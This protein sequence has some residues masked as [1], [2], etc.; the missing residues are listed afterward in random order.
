MLTEAAPKSLTASLPV[1]EE[2]IDASFQVPLGQHWLSGLVTG[3]PRLWT[4]LGNLETRSLAESLDKIA[5]EKPIYIAGIARSGS[6]ILLEALAKHADVAT[7]Q[8][9]DFPCLFTPYWWQR[10]QNS[11]SAETAVERA[12]GDGILVTPQSPEAM[13]EVLWQA[14][15]SDAHN[16][17]Q[18]QVLNKDA[19]H[20]RFEKFYRE[21]LQKLLFARGK[22]RYVSKGNYNFSRLGYLQKLFPEIRCIVPIRSPETHV[23][24]LIKQQI[25]FTRGERKYPRALKHM[26]RVGHYEFGLDRRPI[27]TGNT[28]QIS[29]IET[30][31][32]QGDEVRGWARYWAHLYG[33]MADRLESDEKL[34]RATLVIRYEDL[35]S[36]PSSVLE[37]LRVHTDLE[38]DE[39]FADFAHEIHAPTYY[40]PEFS[41]EEEETIREETAETAARYGYEGGQSSE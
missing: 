10:S 17:E 1:P 19:S 5:I 15:F 39:T 14:F 30:L 2:R 7:H 40:R 37:R 4:M 21:H 33:W 26:Q 23:A 35:C 24:S 36:D 31:W 32:R 25:L 20:P 8:Y 9:R 27:N 16:P 28:E 13:E 29:E 38:S 22:N 41:P 18:S 11:P 12:H 3:W 6:T 34:R